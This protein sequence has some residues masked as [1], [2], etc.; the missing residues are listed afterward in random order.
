MGLND[1]PS[2]GRAHIGFF[3][4]RNAGKSSVVNAVTGQ[5]T[6]IVSALKGTTTDPVYK[7]M[8][9][10]PLGPVVIIDTPGIDDEGALG[11]LRVRKAKQV[12]NKTDAAVLV[13]D[14]LA[15]KTAADEDL[16]RLFREKSVK[17]LVAYNKS[18]LLPGGKGA[19]PAS[20][21]GTSGD[22]IFISAREKFNIEALKE[23]I[24]ALAVTEEPKFRILGDLIGPGDFVVLVT[25]I[26]KAAPKGR[27]ILPQQQTIRDILEG[28]AAAIVVKEFELRETLEH[29]GKKP[30]LVVTDSQVFAKVAADTPRDI[31]LTSFSILFARYKGTLSAAVRGV[32]A[33]DGLRDGDRVLIAE[34]CTHHRQCDD[35]G[36]VKLPRWIRN[37]SGAEP[38][39]TFS[40]GAEFPED[41]SPFK[42]VIHCGACMLNEREV[43]YRQKCTADGGIPFTNYGIV[44]AHIQGILKRSV[45]MFPHVL[46][47]LEEGHEPD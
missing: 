9:L 22:E 47:E 10:L 18:D 45:A 21:P 7:A 43:L 46:A 24:A 19:A 39:F 31:P 36:T 6:A 27:L 1:T 14:A 41:L 12:L 38:D 37:Y 40:S 16:I 4:R 33:I 23:R 29:L 28:D 5:E 11:E 32:R 30:R 42:A 20:P 13:V 2:A 35:I 25:P 8:E 15:G 3:G 44:I 34:G 17:Y 26:D